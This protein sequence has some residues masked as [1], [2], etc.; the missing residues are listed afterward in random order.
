MKPGD[1]HD[2][3]LRLT[4]ADAVGDV[5][6]RHDLGEIRT[7]LE[8]DTM[9]TVKRNRWAAGASA[10][11]VAAT[12]A[13]VAWVTGIGDDDPNDPAASYSPS[14]SPA[15]SDPTA[16]SSP[17]PSAAGP[18]AV[19]YV[20][21]TPSG[22]RLFR[23]FRTPAED[24]ETLTVA[25]GM[26]V[27]ADPLDPDYR[28]PWPAGTTAAASYDEAGDLLTVDVGAGGTGLRTRPAGMSGAEARMALEQLMYTAQAAV[29]ARPPVRFL[30]DGEI[31][32]QLLGE[33]VSEP[34][35][36][37]D[38][39][40]V[41]GPVWVIT[42]QDGDEVEGTFGVEGRGAFF[43]ANVSWQVLQGDR[44]VKDGFGTATECCTLASYEF[45]VEGLP[46]GDY[47]LRVYDAD[48][49][50]GEGPGEQEDTKRL[51]VTG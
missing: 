14:P 37:G 2:E 42:P 12:V 39:M 16:T 36:Q 26:A 19:Y 46:P 4:L 9:N 27:T 24:G 38:P 51:T 18:V 49:S 6:P 25:I 5:E 20:G 43:E 30:L 35:A 17:A 50:G 47:V 1:D 28:V 21:D 33:P 29:Q 31:T 13:A 11:A 34:L 40:E 10:L 7:R 22:P 44:V 23:E 8:E 48:V 15:A 45:S 3:W 41:Q 32:D